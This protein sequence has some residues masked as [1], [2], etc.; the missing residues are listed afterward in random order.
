MDQVQMRRNPQTGLVEEYQPV[1]VVRED[2]VQELEKYTGAAKQLDDTVKA[3][4]KARVDLENQLEKV[5]EQ[6]KTLYADQEGAHEAVAFRA[7]KLKAYDAVPAV[8]PNAVDGKPSGLAEDDAEPAPVA[9]QPSAQDVAASL[10]LEDDPDEPAEQA[11]DVEVPIRR[12]A[13][14]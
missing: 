12:R 8:D 1:P 10:E 13:T 9:G 7:A 14:V 4:E 6:L 11:E 2:L 5:D 3:T